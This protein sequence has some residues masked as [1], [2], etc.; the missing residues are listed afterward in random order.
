MR[1]VSLKLEHLPV[2]SKVTLAIRKEIN[3]ADKGVI[4]LD[5]QCN[6]EILKN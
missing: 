6:V 4:E 1:R 5:I 2:V 3:A